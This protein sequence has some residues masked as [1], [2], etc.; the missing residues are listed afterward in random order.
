MLR[1]FETRH[2]QRLG[3]GSAL[4][5]NSCAA[6]PP[7]FSFCSP[8]SLKVAKC[9]GGF[10]DRRI[11]HGTCQIHVIADWVTCET[12]YFML[13][14][15][16]KKKSRDFNGRDDSD[17]ISIIYPAPLADPP[18]NLRNSDVSPSSL[19]FVYGLVALIISPALPRRCPPTMIK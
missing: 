12:Y 15:A 4:C 2:S 18:A 9:S 8:V 7:L 6:Q 16:P 17:V 11:S 14:D 13:P 19:L 1:V 5:L 10:T 3:R